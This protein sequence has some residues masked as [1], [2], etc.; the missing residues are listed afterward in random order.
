MKLPS[1][2]LFLR[3]EGHGATGHETV[4]DHPT[5]IPVPKTPRREA[6]ADTANHHLAVLIDYDNIAGS[7]NESD[8]E[9]DALLNRVMVHAIEIAPGCW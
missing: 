7:S 1:F 2:P 6:V 5:L 4:S 3:R 9:V 8:A